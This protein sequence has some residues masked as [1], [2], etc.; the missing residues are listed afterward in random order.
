MGSNEKK[1]Y[2]RLKFLSD[3]FLLSSGPTDHTSYLR[4]VTKYFKQFTGA[5]A[6]VLIFNDKNGFLSPVFS[7]GIP[8]NKIKNTRIPSSTRLKDILAHPVLDLRYASFMNTPFIHNRKLLGLSAV[9]S[10]VPEKFLL[11]EQ[12]KYE[13]LLLAMLASYTAV[14]IENLKI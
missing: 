6:S 14:M 11:F 4:T 5:D 9:F 10:T 3:V 13:N 1:L 8:F 7:L 2:Q 12:D